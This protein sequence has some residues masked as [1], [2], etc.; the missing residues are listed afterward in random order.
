MFDF[1]L[2]ASIN[3]KA[4]ECSRH[5][6]WLEV[7]GSGSTFSLRPLLKDETQCRLYIV[8]IN[9]YCRCNL[10]RKFCSTLLVKILIFCQPSITNIMHSFW[11]IKEENNFS[12][13]CPTLAI[14]R[15]RVN[16][17]SRRKCGRG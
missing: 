17:S 16:S 1:V 8:K 5:S 7:S 11:K 2:L 4:A 13:L 10:T 3:K 9:F 15:I 6:S 14:R 12:R